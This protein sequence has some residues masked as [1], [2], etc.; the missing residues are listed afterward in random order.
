[1]PR[2]TVRP[3]FTLV[4]ILV[5]LLIIIAIIVVLFAT[6]GTLSSSRGSNLQTVAAK[7]ASRQVETLRKTD[8]SSLP[9][10][11]SGCSFADSDIAQLPSG[12]ATQTLATY[13]GSADMKLV[14]IQVNWTMQG[15]PRQLKI[16]TLIYKDGI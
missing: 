15:A 12:T 5:S 11:P 10:C 16:D 1:M 13:G 8:Y 2:Y 14:T 7:I 3:G 6:T 9:N 4:E